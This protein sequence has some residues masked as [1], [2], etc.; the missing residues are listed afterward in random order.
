MVD[1]KNGN[2]TL[3]SRYMGERNDNNQVCLIRNCLFEPSQNDTLNA[4]NCLRNIRI[5]FEHKK[6]AIICS[7]R[8]N[9]IGG[10]D[11]NNR[12]RTLRDFEYLLKTIVDIYPNVE[13]MSSDEL[14]DIIVQEYK[15]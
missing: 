12:D 13:F 9:Y 14:G 15:E 8:L 4:E 6:P 1:K 3:Y 10:L 11:L 2:K 7:H 5:M